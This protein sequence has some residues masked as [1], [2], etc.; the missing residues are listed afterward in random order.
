MN[1]FVVHET[2]IG[3]LL[4]ASTGGALV[5][6]QFLKG[7]DLAYPKGW[8]PGDPNGALAETARQLDAYFAGEL[9]VFDLPLALAGT[10]FQQRVWDALRAIPFGKTISY[11]DLATTV[12]S[13]SRAVGGA[14]GANPIGIIV[15][16]HRVITSAGG[17]G[18]YAG[19][20]EQKRRLLE[21]EGALQPALFRG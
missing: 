20:I 19:G 7:V 10:P 1:S 8:E 2:P 16:C 13:G 18:G 9:R 4:L 21:H 14:N 5:H 12:G 11:A 6:V 15:P 3:R 17:L